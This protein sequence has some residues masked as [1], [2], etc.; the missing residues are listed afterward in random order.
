MHVFKIFFEGTA[1][2]LD[3]T[4][5]V[6]TLNGPTGSNKLYLYISLTDLK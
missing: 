1:G 3:G 6:A 5:S 4:T 2:N